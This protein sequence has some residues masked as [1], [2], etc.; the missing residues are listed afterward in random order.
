MRFWY[1]WECCCLGKRRNLRRF[2]GRGSDLDLVTWSLLI[3]RRP[4]HMWR[5]LRIITI[6]HN[7]IARLVKQGIYDLHTT[8][9]IL[10][11]VFD[12]RILD[13]VRD[14]SPF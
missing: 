13:P 11:P 6:L 10:R 1:G 2:Y 5:V 7:L 9:L 3:D 4:S 14:K 8:S 12:V